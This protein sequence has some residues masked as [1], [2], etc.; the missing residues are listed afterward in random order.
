MKNTFVLFCSLF[1]ILNSFGQEPSFND[2]MPGDKL[3]AAPDVT[4]F[5]KQN[6]LPV[7]LYTGRVGIDIPIYEIRAGKISVPISIS[8]NSGGVKVDEIASNVGL[9]WSLN[10]GG[11]I[12]RIIRDLD[13]KELDVY[14]FALP[15]DTM[16]NAGTWENQ[17]NTIGY[18][19]KNAIV[20]YQSGSSSG[21][22]INSQYPYSDMYD[23]IKIDSSPDEYIA[24]APGLSTSFYLK[25]T[26]ETSLSDLFENKEYEAIFLDN[27]GVKSP[28]LSRS[29][30]LVN[31]IGFSGSEDGNPNQNWSNSGASQRDD[32]NNFTL[33]NTAGLEYN[34]SSK[35]FVESYRLPIMEQ[36]QTYYNYDANFTTWHLNTITDASTGNVVTFTYQEYTKTNADSYL[37]HT[38]TNSSTSGFGINATTYF[39]APYYNN[40][41]TLYH[42]NSNEILTKYPKLN[43]LT[44]ISWD[45]GSV[46]FIYNTNRADYIDDKML[47]EIIIKDNDNNIIKKYILEQSY[48]QS[49]ENCA[50]ADCKR[51][52]LN[53]VK[54]I[55]TGQDDQE[56]VFDYEYTNPLPRRTSLRKDFLGY[57]NNNGETFTFTNYLSPSPNPELYF[58]PEDGKYSILPFQR[59]DISN[60]Y[61]KILGYDLASN[62]YSLS[63][64]LKKVTYPTG[65]SSEF[66]YET[67]KFQFFGEEYIAGGARIKKQLLNDGFGNQRE[68][69]YE[70]LESDGSASGYINSIPV[71]AYPNTDIISLSANANTWDTYF[72]TFDKNTSGLELTD[73]SYVGYSRIIEKEVGNGSTEYVY[74]SPNDFPNESETIVN[75]GL[76]NSSQNSNYLINNSAFPSTTFV[77]ND[78]KRGKLVSKVVKSETDEKLSETINTYTYKVFDTVPIFNQ[79]KVPFSLTAQGGPTYNSIIIDTESKINIERNL[80]TKSVTTEYLNGSNISS[81]QNLVYDTDLPFLKE[82]TT[83]DS[84]GNTLKS[85][86]TYASDFL[87]TTSTAFQKLHDENRLSELI[88]IEKYENTTLLEKGKVVFDFNA[89]TTL[90]LPSELQSAKGSETLQTK[91]EYE[92]Y[93]DSGKLLQS[94][95]TNGTSRVYI[96]GYDEQY[97]IAKIEN[98]TYATIEALAAFGA[99]F[100]ITDGL[101]PSQETALRGISGAMV[102]TFTYEP[103]V[104]ITTITDANGYTITYTYDEFNRL[105]Y[106]KDADGNIVSN[107]NYHYK[108]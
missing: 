81:E 60:N 32:F 106:V 36:S 82:T 3:F 101:S 77:N 29:T 92:L 42:I 22:T 39:H 12:T 62:D 72:T 2:P 49:K 100:S 52:K 31:G 57:Y 24:N 8:Y 34:F 28:I 90:T 87:P 50:D 15:D 105:E 74:Y 4:E 85:E 80:Q 41:G 104:G 55:A 94:K 103:L 89:T 30:I 79:G 56:Y 37:N 73:G 47:S 96:W 71:F 40:G 19:R 78:I 18:H 26:Q 59:S 63:G 91:L 45:G 13:D 9:G 84:K 53:K 107:N 102:T 33:T 99:G 21:T 93:S 7:N 69:Q 43:R 86:F 16:D 48:F 68:F 35:D 54:V 25:D 51:L 5:L 11:N 38:V 76:P 14:G 20:S 27:S 46:E 75:T 95:A 17:I 1:A 6:F 65:G 44:E 66:E 10:A 67:H 64:L 97:P 98:T 70:Y 83:T 88:E 23:V 58:Y 108:Q 61:R